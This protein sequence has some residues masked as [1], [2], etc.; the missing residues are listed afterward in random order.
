VRVDRHLSA[1]AC[2]EG[3]LTD[4]DIE[5]AGGIDEMTARLRG[6]AGLTQARF[7]C[8]RGA[9]VAPSSP[10][11]RVITTSPDCGRTW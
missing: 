11:S 9:A 1:A 7:H 3:A 6:S 10:S 4:T 8:G 5:M 2:S